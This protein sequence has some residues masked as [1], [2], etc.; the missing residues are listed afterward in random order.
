MSKI[1]SKPNVELNANLSQA[2]AKKGAGAEHALLFDGLFG[3]VLARGA[4]ADS[5][6]D[7]LD[8]GSN[9]ATSDIDAGSNLHE[10][11][12]ILA[13]MQ[14][15][16]AMMSVQ[17]SKGQKRA[18]SNENANETTDGTTDRD[19]CQNCHAEYDQNP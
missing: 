17:R 11:A 1:A 4:I 14:S 5:D 12:D 18:V 8:I 10:H 13:S 2:P 3:G 15:V 16:A 9:F 7:A 6:A 19:H